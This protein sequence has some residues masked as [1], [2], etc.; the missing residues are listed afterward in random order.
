MLLK[1][2]RR[3]SASVAMTANGRASAAATTFASV[4]AQ[5]ARLQA[6][7]IKVTETLGYELAKPTESAPDWSQ[8]EWHIGRA[9][10]A[11]HGA[12]PLLATGLR[13]RGPA[14]WV[15]FLKQQRAHTAQ[16]HQRIE[17][18]LEDIDRRACQAGIPVLALKGAALLAAGVYQ[19]GERP[20]ADV[21]LLVRP[22][23]SVETVALLQ[24]MGY[25]ETRYAVRDREFC[26]V[27]PRIPSELGEHADNDV[28][29]ELHERISEALPL[30][31]TDITE[32]VFPRQ[33]RP[34]LW[35]IRSLAALHY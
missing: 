32:V 27:K 22:Q 6:A 23:D 13:W 26:P 15:Q 31:K 5:P 17:A 29:I 20:M 4:E 19:A 24:S 10:A 16:R 3:A 2:R 12:S 18:L 25:H 8:F 33:S 11:M 7:L 1:S 35:R 28:T 21:D 30:R 14:A 34:R 9:V